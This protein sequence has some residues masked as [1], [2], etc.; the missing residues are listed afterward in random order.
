MRFLVKVYKV[1]LNLLTSVLTTTDNTH[2][3]GHKFGQIRRSGDD[4][5]SI[6]PTGKIESKNQ[7]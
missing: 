1:A 2:M 4:S 6:R 5:R 7:K 3:D